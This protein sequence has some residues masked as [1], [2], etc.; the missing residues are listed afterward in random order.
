MTKHYRT[1]ESL[2]SIYSCT[3]TITEW[4][5]VFKEEKYFTIIIDSFKYCMEH[6]GLLL[7][8]FVIMPSHIHLMNS[9]DEYHPIAITSEKW[10]LQKM[11]YMH[12]NQKRPGS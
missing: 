4:L 10:F 11:E 3:C 8:G 2:T 7:L 12:N 9:Q 6:K 5:C 1:D